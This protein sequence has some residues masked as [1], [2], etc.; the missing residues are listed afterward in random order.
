MVSPEEVAGQ[1]RWSGSARLLSID[2]SS[3]NCAGAD[4]HQAYH[5]ADHQETGGEEV[6]R[7]RCD[8]G[9]QITDTP[10]CYGRAERS[11]SSSAKTGGRMA[12]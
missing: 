9:Q 2:P 7:E 3:R 4:F 10:D 5:Q 1:A 6:Q 8:G 12:V 11:S